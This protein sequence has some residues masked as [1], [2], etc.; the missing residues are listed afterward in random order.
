LKTAVRLIAQTGDAE[1]LSIRTLSAEVGVTPPS[2]YRHFTDKATI[3]RAVVEEQFADFTQ[4]L[5]Q[6]GQRSRSPFASLRR[7]CQ[8]YLHF[9]QE[10]PGRYR[11]LFSAASLGPANLGLTDQPHPGAT[12]FYALV[13]SVQRCIEAGAKPGGDAQFVAIMLWSTLHGF[14]DLRIGKPEMPWPAADRVVRDLLRRL[15]LDGPAQQ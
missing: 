1:G 12:S 7:R 9:A 8:A 6:A 10:E 5:D 2:I 15:R 13:S 11:V 4:R 3:L 14:A